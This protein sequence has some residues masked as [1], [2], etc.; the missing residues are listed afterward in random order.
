[1]TIATIDIGTNTVLLLVATVDT[2]GSLRTLA[3]EQRIPRLGRGVDA[4]RILQPE[5]ISR[6]VHV[7]REYTDI[8]KRY[9]VDHV[10]VC[11]TSAV[12]DAL[13]RLELVD[14]IHRETGYHLEV[15]SGDDEAVWTYRGAISGLGHAGSAVVLDIGG[16]STEL[17]VG[18]GRTIGQRT[19]IDV[20]SVRL[21][22]RFFKSDPPAPSEIQEAS[23]MI[24]TSLKDSNLHLP[25][26]A[27]W[28]GVAG[29]VTTLVL[30]A[31]GKTSF[32]VEGVTN[33]ILSHSDVHA[34]FGRF[35]ALRASDIRKI[36]A[37]LEGRADVILAG[38][39]VLRKIMERY[40]IPMITVS[41]R[42]LRYGLAIREWERTEGHASN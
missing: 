6:V 4:R 14:A 7:L 29:T 36:S 39:L 25:D 35:A 33:T 8:I 22:E 42:G 11:G 41:E 37:V 9:A 19:S 18:D 31:Q 1:M 15:L 38:T 34:M 2:R 32:A 27:Q 23:A 3:Y 21:T 24:D 12:R 20:G 40:Q 30:V 13:N 17:I 5:A 16:G 26:G 28:V 10:L